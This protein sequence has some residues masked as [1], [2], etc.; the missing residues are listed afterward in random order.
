MDKD[1][2][3]K[4][5]TR[6]LTA[7]LWKDSPSNTLQEI[8]KLLPFKKSLAFVQELIGKKEPFDEKTVE[9]WIRNL[10]PK[11]RSKK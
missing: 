11:Y 2:L 10:N 1:Q 5:K 7:I 8:R 4:L 3:A 9:D 6:C